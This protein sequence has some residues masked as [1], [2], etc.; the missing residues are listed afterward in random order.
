MSGPMS[1]DPLVT[2]ILPVYNGADTLRDAL[3]SVVQQTY[4]NLEILVV[5]DG[6]TDAPAPSPMPSRPAT[7][8]CG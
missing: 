6:S 7:R 1:A 4:S 2:V 5:D 8:V 3:E